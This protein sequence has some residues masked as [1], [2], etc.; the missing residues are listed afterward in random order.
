MLLVMLL[1][2]VITKEELEEL[3]SLITDILEYGNQSS[4]EIENSINELL[5]ILLGVAADGKITNDEFEAL[6]KWLIDNSHIS[7]KW[8]AN[9]L[10]ERIKDFKTDGVVDEEEKHDLLESLKKITG[11]RFDETGDAHGAIAE[12]FSDEISEFYHQDKKVCFTGKFVC[13]TRSVCEKSAREKGAIIAK[14][15]TTDL[16]VLILGTLASRDWRF[17]SHGR[18]IEKVLEYREK[19]REII[20]LSERTWLKFT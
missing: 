15:I 4:K 13:G 14:S 16:D 20:I 1:R 2:V 10:I 9:I 8:P 5:G 7:D 12:V 11:Q 19:G 6:D 3:N 18:K 17:T